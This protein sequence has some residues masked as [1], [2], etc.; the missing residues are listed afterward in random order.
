LDDCFS[1]GNNFFFNKECYKNGCPNG[2]ISLN[3]IT[4]EQKK[5]FKNKILLDDNLEDKLCICNI[6]DGFWSNIES[7][8]ENE[9][10]FQKCLTECS[11]GYEPEDL[12]NF[13]IEKTELST[14]I[15]IF[16]K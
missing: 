9:L 15:I 14:L 8:S 16:F 2:K 3:D 1:K 6:N 7:N 12:T 11:K 13:C 10:Y 5:Y 4:E